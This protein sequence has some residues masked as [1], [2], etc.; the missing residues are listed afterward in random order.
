MP[1][2][3][4]LPK[5]VGLF[6]KR[7]VLSRVKFAEKN[8]PAVV[9]VAAG[10]ACTRTGG[11]D[12]ILGVYVFDTPTIFCRVFCSSVKSTER[13]RRMGCVDKWEEAGMSSR[14]GGG[15]G[16]GG[17]RTGRMKGSGSPKVCEGACL[18]HTKARQMGAGE[19]SAD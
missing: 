14:E 2:S 9:V 17:W 18:L 13:G 1:T 8:R 16:W 12:R 11:R 7:K 15:G 4:R 10:V 3:G 5:F 6:C 19:R